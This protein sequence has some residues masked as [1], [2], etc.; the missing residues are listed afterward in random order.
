MAAFMK[1]SVSG[2]VKGF[3]TVLSPSAPGFLFGIY[4]ILMYKGS[5]HEGIILNR[6][7]QSAHSLCGMSSPEAVKYQMTS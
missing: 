1:Y 2:V 6:Y 7:F 3:D 4:S 5:M